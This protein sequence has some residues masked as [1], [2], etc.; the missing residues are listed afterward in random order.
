MGCSWNRK[1]NPEVDRAIYV[2]LINE[3]R[4]RRG[5]EKLGS[6]EGSTNYRIYYQK[7]LKKKR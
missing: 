6:V 2:D 3:L 4:T 1:F 7:S 5:F